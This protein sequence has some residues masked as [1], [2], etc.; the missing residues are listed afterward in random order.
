MPATSA[1]QWKLLKKRLQA[2]PERRPQARARVRPAAGE[3]WAA[4]A[5]VW[6]VVVAAEALPA[7]VAAWEAAAARAWAAVAVWVA[8]AAEKTAEFKCR[9]P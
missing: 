2:H 3:A 9:L 4:A 5:E 1:R 8:V 6:A 7:A